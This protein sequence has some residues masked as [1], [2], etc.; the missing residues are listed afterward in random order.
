MMRNCN[1]DCNPPGVLRD[2]AAGPRSVWCPSLLAGRAVLA[3]R[4]G[5]Q[6]WP[7]RNGVL[8]LRR[9]WRP[10]VWRDWAPASQPA[11]HPTWIHVV[12]RGQASPHSLHRPRCRAH[13]VSSLNK[14]RRAA[15]DRRIGAL[16]RSINHCRGSHA[17]DPV[18]RTRRS[19]PV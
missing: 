5:G 6:G 3:V 16:G 14:R 12:D 8:L 1:P 7:A 15:A 17:D 13:R 18:L 2:Q 10:V 19:R 9:L 11:V 4:A